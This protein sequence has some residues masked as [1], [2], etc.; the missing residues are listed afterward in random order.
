LK[1]SIPRCEE[2]EIKCYGV[3]FIAFGEQAKITIL[4]FKIIPKLAPII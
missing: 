2:N 4:A 3:G 1:V